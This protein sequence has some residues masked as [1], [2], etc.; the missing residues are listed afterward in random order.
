[1][2][3]VEVWCAFAMRVFGISE[4]GGCSLC[5]VCVIFM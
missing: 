2:G 1:M 5:D 4:F 3:D